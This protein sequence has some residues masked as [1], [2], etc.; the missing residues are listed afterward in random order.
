MKTKGSRCERENDLV[1]EAVN[2]F[3]AVCHP[4]RVIPT[5]TI[6]RNVSFNFSFKEVVV[7]ATKWHKTE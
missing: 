6:W 2:L 7:L 1:G 3:Q 4:V 5:T